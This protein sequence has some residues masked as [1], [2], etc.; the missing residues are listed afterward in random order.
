MPDVV[1]GFTVAQELHR[2]GR[3]DLAEQGYRQVLEADPQHAA[4]WRMLGI[5]A[6]DSGRLRE[7]I[8]FLEEGLFSVGPDPKLYY[9]LGQTYA[10]AGDADEAIR[11]HRLSLTVLEAS[12][13]G[14]LALGQLLLARRATRGDRAF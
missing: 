14:H 2:T 7:A 6:R 4:A 3:L 10:A 13:Q 1:D 8:V 5:L 11:S 9:H 12:P